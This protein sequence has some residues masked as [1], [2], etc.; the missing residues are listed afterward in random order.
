MVP[1]YYVQLFWVS[2][3][4]VRYNLVLI[5]FQINLSTVLRSSTGKHIHQ[6]IVFAGAVVVVHDVAKLSTMKLNR[7]RLEEPGVV[8]CPVFVPSLPEK[9]GKIE[10]VITRINTLKSK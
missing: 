1:F 6:A 7:S 8:P 5:Y 3:Q 4:F 10:I 2:K 9:K